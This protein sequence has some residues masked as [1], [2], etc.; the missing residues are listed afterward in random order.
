ML[1]RFWRYSAF[2]LIELLVVVAIIAI[3]A[4]MLLPALSAAREKARRASCLTNLN[5]IGKGLES[6]CSDY[7][8]YFPSWPGWERGTTYLWMTTSAANGIYKDPRTGDEVWSARYARASYYG[9]NNMT[10]GFGTWRNADTSPAHVEYDCCDQ[11]HC[12]KGRLNMAPV[13]LGLLLT[14]GAVGDAQVFYC[15][16][17][18]NMP[19]SPGIIYYKN[20]ATHQ[21]LE[22]WKRSGGYRAEVLTH[23][24]RT[25]V[26]K[27]TNQVSWFYYSATTGN[28]RMQECHYM[29]RNLPLMNAANIGSGY[30]IDVK[31][32]YVKPMT[33][34][35]VGEPPFKTQRLL[36]GRAIVTSSFS[37]YLASATPDPSD[38]RYRGYG[39]YEHK[40]GYN[41][42][43]G[44]SH[45]TWYGDPAQ[46]IA[47]DLFWNEKSHSAV[48]NYCPYMSGAHSV[49][50][51]TSDTLFV[52]GGTHMG[53]HQFDLAAGIDAKTT[54][55]PW[56]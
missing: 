36:Q 27:G 7:G 37:R 21:G 34:V 41:V 39:L 31:L 18:S 28:G 16:S 19:T 32:A 4:A 3:L 38:A 30:D 9:L 52:P 15:P 8:Q 10:I 13:G 35:A 25:W 56:Q 23:G 29:Y 1:L 26:A 43:Y 45:A 54:Y 44:D 2:T 11:S 40:D 12:V 51:N 14:T 22:S 5:Q 46:R 55:F 53:F 33:T 20:R 24:D 17:A 47:W 42:L 50:H 48:A 6:Y 49:Q